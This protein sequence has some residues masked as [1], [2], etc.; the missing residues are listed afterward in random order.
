[1]DLISAQFGNVTNGITPRRW[2][3]QCN[4]ALSNLITETLGGDKSTWLK[5]LYKLKGLLKHADNP[6]FQSKWM[7]AKQKNKERLAHYARETLG[8]EVDTKSLF[9]VQIKRIH[10]YKRQTMNIFGVIYRYLRLK[11]MEPE[12]RKKQQPRTNIFGGKAAPGYYMAKLVR[13]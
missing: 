2:L 10:E 13:R 1:M 9:D 3:D 8:V 12:E 11:S 4:P 7:A 6:E 5:D